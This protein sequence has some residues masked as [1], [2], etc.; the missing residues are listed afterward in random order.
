LICET[1]TPQ[2]SYKIKNALWL[3]CNFNTKTAESVETFC[4][5]SFYTEPNTNLYLVG[6]GLIW[7][8]LE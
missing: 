4:F 3:F 8:C 7:S 1:V 2:V 5:S 6:L